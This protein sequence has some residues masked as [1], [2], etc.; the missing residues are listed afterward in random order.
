MNEPIK[1]TEMS[2]RGRERLVGVFVLVAAVLLLAGFA[3]YLYRT[4]ERRGWLVPRCPYYTFVMSAD[5]LGVGDPVR[6]MGFE[7]GQITGIEA[8]P[9][10]SYYNVFV[11]I[12]IQ[13]PY[14][15]YIWTDSKIRVATAG[16]L[17]RQLEVLK[18]V[19]G[20]ATITE[21]DGRP[22]E[23][24]QDG[25]FVALATVPKG[26]FL[27]PEESA[28]VGERAEKLLGQMEAALPGV[29]AVTNRLN[30]VLDNAN[31]LLTG[32]HSLL[33]NADRTV[34]QLQ[35]ALSNV[36]VIT[37]HLRDPRGSLGEWLLPTD[38]HTN[39]VNVTGGLNDTLLNLAAITSNLNS[40][41]ESNHQI[42]AEISRLVVNT[43]HLVQGLKKHWLLRGVFRSSAT[44]ATATTSSRP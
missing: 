44:N 13:R 19:A 10:G 40:Q 36:V 24:F 43:D 35:P 1:T 20:T 2:G 9:P 15:G 34:T 14:Y 41:V 38:L 33:A 5:G 8:M 25:K 18:G 22:H 12:E 3:Y 21:K 11:S 7:I 26:A 6:M 31:G 30:A 4:A 37:D 23:V 42:L 28:S 27:L 16:L 29:L 39:L 32:A 17:G